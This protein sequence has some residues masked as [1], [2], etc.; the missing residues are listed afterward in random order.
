[1]TAQ[2][3][4][5][6]IIGSP[7]SFGPPTIPGARSIE[8]ELCKGATYFSPF[9]F[10]RPE[11]STG[12]FIC[13]TCAQKME[14]DAEIGAIEPEQVR[15]MAEGAIY[16]KATEGKYDGEATAILSIVQ[17][18]AVLI[19]VRNGRE[20][21]GFSV[22]CDL[23]KVTA[24]DVIGELPRVLRSIADAIERQELEKAKGAQ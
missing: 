19:A 1:M 20:G 18:D 9:S 22:A 5:V 7:A 15:E 11:A 14:G 23:R 6:Y 16:S 4:Q 17:G 12:K 2:D 10:T 3:R 8:C 24:E 13:L 21:D